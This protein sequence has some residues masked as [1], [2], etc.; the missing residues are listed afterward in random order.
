MPFKLFQINIKQT[1]SQQQPI[2]PVTIAYM[3]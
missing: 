2:A 3:S 1:K